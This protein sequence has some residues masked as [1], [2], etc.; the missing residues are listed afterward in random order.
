ML[1]KT[2]PRRSKRQEGL[3]NLRS[4]LQYNW[5]FRTMGASSKFINDHMNSVHSLSEICTIS[6]KCVFISHR[7]SDGVM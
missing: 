5:S 1:H 6:S 4:V 3:I 7:R 2:S